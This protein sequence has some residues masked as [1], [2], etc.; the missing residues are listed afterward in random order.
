MSAVS[1]NIQQR[2][3]QK[4]VFNQMQLAFVEKIVKDH[5]ANFRKIFK[6]RQVN[7]I[8][9]DNPEL[10]FYY[11]HKTD[12]I[13]R[14]KVRIR[15]YGNTFGQ[16]S[17]PVLEFKFR[18]GDLRIKKSFKLPEFNIKEDFNSNLI[19]EVL[20]KA[21]LPS[22]VFDETKDLEAR[23]LNSYTRRYYRSNN[24]H[25]RFTIDH[26]LEYYKFISQNNLYSQNEI[27]NSN[28]I[29]EL[30]FGVKFASQASNINNQLPKQDYVFSK[31][32]SGMEKV[33]SHLT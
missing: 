14:M 8:Y 13:D 27:D 10:K 11:D 2:Y 28:V 16:V 32:V 31:Y 26:K 24:L 1:G 29:L 25:F 20:A 30:K 9:L 7:N 33:Y 18:R 15:W 22:K 21:S 3:E 19:K 17:K 5:P 6:Q 4:F 23:L 12:N